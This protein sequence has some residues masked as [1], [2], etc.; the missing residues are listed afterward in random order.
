MIWAI[1]FLLALV[2]AAAGTAVFLIRRQHGK[3]EVRYL[4]GGV[5]LACVAICFPVMCLT[6]TGGICSGGK[7]IPQ[8]PHVCSDSGVIR[9]PGRASGK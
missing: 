3:N 4:G 5:F 6:G 9:Y 7:Y 8:Y 1:C 2:F